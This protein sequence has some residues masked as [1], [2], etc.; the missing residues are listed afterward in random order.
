MQKSLRVMKRDG[1]V[2]K[3]SSQ[4]IFKSISKSLKETG[5]K[6]KKLAAKLTKHA[7]SL[8]TKRYKGEVV[9]VESIKETVEFVLV[10]NKL[11]QVAKRYALYRYV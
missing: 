2:E 10:K 4:K 11:P 8:L 7:V 6:N 3:F 9:P 1:T 5:Y